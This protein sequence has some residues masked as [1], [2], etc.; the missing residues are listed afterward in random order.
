[1]H[2]TPDYSNPLRASAQVGDTIEFLDKWGTRRVGTV[3]GV[4]RYHH[5]PGANTLTVYDEDGSV[6]RDI[7]TFGYKVTAPA[8]DALHAQRRVQA[9]REHLRRHLIQYPVWAARFE[10]GEMGVGF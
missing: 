9:A 8:A 5:A 6:V 4:T 1:M 3:V 2:Y 10:Q 7:P